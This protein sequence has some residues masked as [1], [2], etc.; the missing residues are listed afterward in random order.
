MAGAEKGQTADKV[1]VN[2]C[3]AKISYPRIIERLDALG[4]PTRL[5]SRNAEPPFD[6]ED[7]TTWPEQYAEGLEQYGLPQDVASLVMRLF[8]T[9]PDGGNAY[10]A[11]DVQRAL[12]REPRDFTDYA[13]ATAA[14]GIWES[15]R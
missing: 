3:G 9:V 13:R 10:L 4:D 12:G 2:I 5:S 6:W 1:S 8:T 14:T 15:Q 7:R 11:D